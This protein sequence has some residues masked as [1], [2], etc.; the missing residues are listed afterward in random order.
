MAK[1]SS[2]VDDLRDRLKDPAYAAQYLN[3][4][5]TET[6]EGEDAAFLLALRDVAEA[7]QMSKVAITAGVNRENLYRMLS[8]R[9]NPRLSSLVAVIKAL[10]LSLSVQP[11]S[12][13]IV[14]EPAHTERSRTVRRRVPYTRPGISARRR[15]R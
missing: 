3:Y 8:P 14:A 4:V 13:A 7:L 10:G 12:E 5:L 11:A 2:Y 6:S 1:K 15:G 9:G